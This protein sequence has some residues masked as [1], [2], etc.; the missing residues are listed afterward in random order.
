MMGNMTE[1]LHID[2]VLA[3]CN[4][5]CIKK[6]NPLQLEEAV[7]AVTEA[8]AFP[9]VSVVIFEEPC[10]A[11]FKS[12]PKLQVDAAKCVGCRRCVQEIG[13]P[14]ISLTAAG[15]ALID[16]NLCYGCDLCSQLCPTGAI[17]GSKK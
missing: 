6:A 16:E 13:C 7:A 3:G 11:L 8:V 15:K 1:K 4:V 2:Q 5:K 12:R 9:G 17:G 10:I 14:A